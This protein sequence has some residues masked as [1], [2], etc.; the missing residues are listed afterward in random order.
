MAQP[1][2]L[3]DEAAPAAAGRPMVYQVV[4]IDLVFACV[5]SYWQPSARE[6]RDFAAVCLPFARV[7]K[8]GLKQSCELL[9]CLA[10]WTDDGMTCLGEASDALKQLRTDLEPY[11]LRECT[12]AIDR[13]HCSQL[14]LGNWEVASLMSGHFRE[15]AQVFEESTSLRVG[16][17]RAREHVATVECAVLQRRA[18]TG[19]DLLQLQLAKLE[20]QK[21]LLIA[22][23]EGRKQLELAQID[24]R[25]ELQFTA[26]QDLHQVLM[27][28]LLQL[29]LAQ[30]EDRMRLQVTEEENR[31]LMHIAARQD[32]Q[33]RQF[34]A[35]GREVP[36]VAEGRDLQQPQSPEVRAPECVGAQEEPTS[37]LD[38]AVTAAD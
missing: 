38:G 2:G 37:P 34:A 9:E 14:S 19:R 10:D 20:D 28:D 36:Q 7:A 4:G 32:W 27:A 5:T 31:I 12:S 21:Q 8:R 1:A 6:W 15:L 25:S 13:F 11:Q 35:R 23:I 33:K 22:Q 30:I 17:A 29:L 26:W 18:G 3:G 16:A 24:A